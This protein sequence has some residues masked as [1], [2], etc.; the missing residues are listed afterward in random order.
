MSNDTE[1]TSV[2][3]QQDYE[4]IQAAVMETERGRWFLT[5]YAKRNRVA[6]TDMLLTAIQKLETSVAEKSTQ[7]PEN[8]DIERIRFDI[9]D[10]ASA[11]SETKQQIASIN[12]ETDGNSNLDTATAELDAIVQAAENATSDI[13]QAAENI[14][15]VA[16]TI[17]EE[18]AKEPDFDKLDEL[19]TDIYTACSFQDITGQR[20]SK[21]INVLE[22][23][24]AR[25][26]AM[27]N[28]WDIDQAPIAPT[29][30]NED[31]REDSHLLNGPQLDGHGIDQQDIDLVMADEEELF[32][33]VVQTQDQMDQKASAMEEVVLDDILIEEPGT[34]FTAAPEFVL[35]DLIVR[36]IT[37]NEDVLTEPELEE[38]EEAEESEESAQQEEAPAPI[39]NSEELEALSDTDKMAMFT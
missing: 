8:A 2:A 26:M 15:E 20:I 1:T 28:I 9:A 29:P 35:D 4:A 39:D 23:L 16:W 10:M 17:R 30:E 7:P 38:P 6:N 37:P 18:G 36:E 33:A 12:A 22:F 27:M 24:E 14:Q 31:T 19:V 21:V 5:E 11:I 3:Q 32:D 25:V 13:L 34:E